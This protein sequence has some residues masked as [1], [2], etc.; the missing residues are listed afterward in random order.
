[1][2]YVSCQ[3]QVGRNGGI[4]GAGETAQ[5]EDDDRAKH[6]EHGGRSPDFTF[7]QSRHPREELH[8]GWDR[9][10]QGYYT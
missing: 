5:Q 1:M 8:T 3:M 6:K 2:K 9:H 7:P 4:R 10:E